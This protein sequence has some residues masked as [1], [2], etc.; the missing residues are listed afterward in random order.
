MID[1]DLLRYMKRNKTIDI[2]KM[3]AFK[4][5]F[6]DI[7]RFCAIFNLTV[8]DINGFLCFKDA[9]G[10]E[11]DNFDKYTLDNNKYKCITVIFLNQDDCNKFAATF[12][13]LSGQLICDK[14][15]QITMES[16]DEAIVENTRRNMVD[17]VDNTKPSNIKFVTHSPKTWEQFD[18]WRAM[19]EYYYNFKKDQ[20]AKIPVFFNRE[21]FTNAVLTDMLGQNIHKKTDSVWFPKKEKN[22]FNYYRVLGGE[23]PK[24]PIFVISKGR[25]DQYKYHTSQS[26]SRIQIHHYLCVEPQEIEIY[27]KSKLNESEYCHIIEMDMTY[28]DK[29]DPLGD[30]GT[31]KNH[32]PGPARNFCG[33]FARKLGAK[34]CWILDDNT[35]DFFRVWRGRRILAFTPEIFRSCERFVERYKNIA[36][37]GLQYHMFVINQDP[38]PP[39]VLNTRVFSYHLWNLEAMS[40][41]G[42]VQRGRYNDDVIL[43][44]DLLTKGWCSVLFN[45]YIA[46]KLRTQVLKGGCTTDIYQEK[47][48]GTFAKSQQ[49][50]EVYPEYT[51]LVWKFKRWHHEVDY[52]KFRQSLIPKDEYK[53]MIEKDYN[54]IDEH[55]AYIVRI[56]PKYHLDPEKDNRPF[57]ESIYPK[58]CPEDITQDLM[59]LPDDRNNIELRNFWDFETPGECTIERL[60]RNEVEEDAPKKIMDS[61]LFSDMPPQEPAEK[62]KTNE[63]KPVIPPELTIEEKIAVVNNEIEGKRIFD[64]QFSID[65]L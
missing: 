30:I 38:R 41:L 59:Y 34:W 53:E 27:S 16:M 18:H 4:I 20:Y 33:D 42:V 49:L 48:G 43:S 44:L 36:I 8:E 29:F 9:D 50:C 13:C 47:F 11:V 45:C 28:K 60:Y 7:Q 57:L 46:R 65:N 1:E 54:A 63:K 52:T 51:S 23:D 24:F 39:M 32:G 61:E 14:T 58:G 22:E 40:Q 64:E 21:V 3:D 15:T 56:D 31:T 55:S 2:S 35:E 19:P 17:G 62:K 5:T 10:K 6:D 12:P 26:L 37:A 25:S